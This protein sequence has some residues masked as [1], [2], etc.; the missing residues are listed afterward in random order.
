MSI[1]LE[2]K[3][4]SPELERQLAAMSADERNRY[5][6]AVLEE[7]F[8]DLE[9]DEDALLMIGPPSRRG[10]VAFSPEAAARIRAAHDE[11]LSEEALALWKKAAENYKRLTG[12]SVKEG[13]SRVGSD[14]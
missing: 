12:K 8:V 5:A 13:A 3:E 6:T 2:L 10:P 14:R 11:P 4:L 1:T 9:D 7:K